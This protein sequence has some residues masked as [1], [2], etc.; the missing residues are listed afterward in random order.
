MLDVHFIKENPSLV[1][2]NIKKKFQH[3]KLLLVAEIIEKY[4]DWLT[5]K[6]ETEI[7]RARRNTLSKEVNKLKK[8][9]K[10][11]SK[12]LQEAKDLPQKITEKEDQ[13]GILKKRISEIQLQIPNIIHKSVPLGKDEAKNKPRKKYGVHKKFTFKIK[14]HV[15]LTEQLGVADFESS[16]RTSGKGF[17]FL[18][19]RLAELNQA[20]I[21]FGIDFMVKKKYTLIEP[22]LMVRKEVVDGVVS[23]EDFLDMIYKIENE[24]L[25]LIGTSEHSLIGKFINQ[26]IPEEKLPIKLAAV[27]NCFRKEIGSHGVNEKGL[28]RTHQFSKVEQIVICKPEDS[29]KYF[30]ELLKNSTEI[31]KK[32]K[33]P[34]RELEFCSGDLG[35]LKAKQ[36]DVEVF[37][38]TTKDYEEVGSCSN[39]TDAQAR[40]LNIKIVNKKGEKRFAH[41]LNNTAIATSRAMVAILENFQLKDGSVKVPIVLQKYTGFKK[42]EK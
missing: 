16:A 3:H 27:S 18:Q 5:L 24:D 35:D 2:E 23:F 36:V 42:I 38:P 8:Q 29:Y 40:L 1:K 26:T 10:D 7:L 11:T 6:K 39:L 12:I 17:Y 37:R 19:G 9:K 30:D 21:R 13:T 32:L 15:E 22:P 14:N 20:L 33:I 41:T 4:E 34:I 31:Y 28:W 25:Y